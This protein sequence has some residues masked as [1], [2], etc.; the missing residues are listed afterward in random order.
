MECLKT[1]LLKIEFYYQRNGKKTINLSNRL[2]F[3]QKIIVTRHTFIF[4]LHEKIN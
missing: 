2:K 1:N 4:I 3:R